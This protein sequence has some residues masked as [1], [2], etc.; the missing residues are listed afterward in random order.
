M[1]TGPLRELDREQVELASRGVTGIDPRSVLDQVASQRRLLEHPFYRAWQAG[2]LTKADLSDYAAQYR[3]IEQI[4]PATLEAIATTLPAGR[5]RQFVEA[6]LA[7]ERSLPRP[8]LELFDAFATAVDADI[9]TPASPATA[10]LVAVYRDAARAGTVAALA[11]IGAYEVQASEVAATKAASLR[12]QYDLDLAG[13]E[14]WDVHA[15]LEDS[16]GHW[17]AE[18]IAELS[19]ALDDIRPCAE[20]SAAAWWAFLDEREEARQD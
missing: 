1:P 7:D 10:R 20:A 8:H 16:H 15:L 13:T 2:D 11:V 4:L 14:F 5:A 3:H 17:T 18:A 19:P 12:C 6:N 9:A